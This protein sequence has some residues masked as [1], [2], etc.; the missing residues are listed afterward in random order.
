[1]NKISKMKTSLKLRAIWLKPSNSKL[2]G[3]YVQ[4]K[5]P[6]SPL[7]ANPRAIELFEKMW[8]NCQPKNHQLWSNIPQSVATLMVKCLALSKPAWKLGF[9]KRRLQPSSQPSPLA[10][11]RSDETTCS[12]VLFCKSLPCVTLHTIFQLS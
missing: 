6:P 7:W 9:A 2:L 4:I 12:K 1:M 8:S 3:L 11:P 10:T 5:I